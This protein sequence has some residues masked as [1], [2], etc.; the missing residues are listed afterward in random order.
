MEVAPHSEIFIALWLHVSWKSLLDKIIH[1]FS[2]VAEQCCSITSEILCFCFYYRLKMIRYKFVST[3]VHW[4]KSRSMQMFSYRKYIR[5]FFSA[6]FFNVSSEHSKL[7][8]LPPVC[9]FSKTSTSSLSNGSIERQHTVRFVV[10]MMYSSYWWSLLFSLYV[11]SI[12]LHC[13]SQVH[14]RHFLSSPTHFLIA[15]SITNCHQLR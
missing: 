5:I 15:H 11:L 12:S 7:T 4:E 1:E 2:A 3:K 10:I 6:S 8:L 9:L 13:N 14:I